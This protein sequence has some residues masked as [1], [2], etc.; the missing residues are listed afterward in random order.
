MKARLVTASTA[1]ILSAALI[2]APAQATPAVPLNI[3]ALGDSVAS[4][5]GASGANGVDY[6]PG[7]NMPGGCY[8]SYKSYSEQLVA[9]LRAAGKL[10][11]FTNKTC[12]GATTYSVRQTQLGALNASTTHVL[13]TVGANN[14]QFAKYAGICI[15]SDCSGAPSAITGALIG[16]MIV[17]LSTLLRKIKQLAPQAQVIMVGYGQPVTRNASTP[18]TADRI[19]GV[20]SAAERNTPGKLFEINDANDVSAYLDLALFGTALAHHVDY[21]SP[22]AKFGT[23]RSDFADH[24]LCDTEQSF[25][26]GFDALDPGGDGDIAVIHPK[27]KWQTLASQLVASELELIG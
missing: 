25:Y 7:T 22:Y 12:S 27:M 19:C 8:R 24:S 14:L 18:D 10:V 13:L 6:Q 4:G 21:V 20:F 1:A 11:N 15:F 16:P 5:V 2:V 23:L 17:D 3:V 26:H 9:R